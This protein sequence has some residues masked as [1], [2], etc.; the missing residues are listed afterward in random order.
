MIDFISSTLFS[1]TVAWALYFGMEGL[2]F[3][4][5]S[6]FPG[7]WALAF[8]AV[9]LSACIIGSLVWAARHVRIVIV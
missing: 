7:L 9:G 6:L 5:Y 4:D 2:G 3:T 8:S 1:A